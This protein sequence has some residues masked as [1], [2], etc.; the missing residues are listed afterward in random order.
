MRYVLLALLL[1]GCATTYPEFPTTTDPNITF[2]RNPG[3]A[4]WGCKTRISIDGQ[5]T[6]VVGIGDILELQASAGRHYVKAVADSGT[7][8][9][10]EAT[11][12]VVLKMNSVLNIK[13]EKE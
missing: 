9:N 6:A 12:I 13:V 7:C 5:L 4:G 3:F 10:F 8:S 2:K 1:T 11:R